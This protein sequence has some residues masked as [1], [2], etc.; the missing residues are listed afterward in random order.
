MGETGLRNQPKFIKVLTYSVFILLGKHN[1]GS[2]FTL[3]RPKLDYVNYVFWEWFG[4]KDD[5]EL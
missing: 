2:C 1:L 4:G 5:A 3:R